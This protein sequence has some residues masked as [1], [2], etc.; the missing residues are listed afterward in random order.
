M[1]EI[2]VNEYYYNR[3]HVHVFPANSNHCVAKFVIKPFKYQNTSILE[4]YHTER[5]SVSASAS[6]ITS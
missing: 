6:S 3:W 4:E 5:H 2:L 1:S